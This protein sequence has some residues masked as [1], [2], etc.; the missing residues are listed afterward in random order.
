MW[1]WKGLAHKPDYKY[2]ARSLLVCTTLCRCIWSADPEIN[3]LSFS[4]LKVTVFTLYP[5]WAGL[6]Q[7]T[8]TTITGVTVEWLMVLRERQINTRSLVLTASFHEFW[9]D[10][11]CEHDQVRVKSRG[12]FTTFHS[13]SASC[14][15][16]DINPLHKLTQISNKELQFSCNFN[17]QLQLLY[18]LLPFYAQYLLLFL[19]KKSVNLAPFPCA[20]MVSAHL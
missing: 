14:G 20:F 18:L 2:Y 8:D 13:K 3:H 10:R 12:I 1:C 15:D 7:Q 4:P 9:P 5:A 16:N 11:L 19:K 6:W 17:N